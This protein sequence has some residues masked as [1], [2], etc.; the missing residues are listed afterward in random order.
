MSLCRGSRILPQNQPCPGH[1]DAEPRAGLPPGVRTNPPP[2]APGCGRDAA[3][4]GQ[5]ESQGR[6][7][8]Q[9]CLCPGLPLSAPLGRGTPTRERAGSLGGPRRAGTPG[10]PEHRHPGPAAPGTGRG[11]GFRGQPSPPRRGAAAASLLG[12]HL[13]LH[14][15]DAWGWGGRRVPRGGRWLM[16]EI[17]PLPVPAAGRCWDKLVGAGQ[18]RGPASARRPRA[19]TGR[20]GFSADFFFFPPLRQFRVKEGE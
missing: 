7:P 20:F 10:A 18:V 12:A 3:W 11:T 14:R 13:P 19:H 16:P 5:P 17:N 9:T 4:R 15:C 6:G 8:S 1:A 2:R